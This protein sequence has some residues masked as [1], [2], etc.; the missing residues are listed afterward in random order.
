MLWPIIKL[1]L[2]LI[3]IIKILPMMEYESYNTSSSIYNVLN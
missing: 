2:L 1:Q 3:G